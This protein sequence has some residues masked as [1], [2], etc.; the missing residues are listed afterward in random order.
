MSFDYS[1]IPTTQEECNSFEGV[2]AGEYRVTITD[3]SEAISSNGYEF[4]KMST[5]VIGGNHSGRKINLTFWTGGKYPESAYKQ[6]GA[7]MFAAKGK[8]CQLHE[9][10]NSTLLLTIKYKDGNDFPRFAG[11]KRDESPA[12]Q[13]QAAPQQPAPQAAPVDDTPF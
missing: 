7:I 8:G 9:L 4:V 10:V 6:L 3:C 13:Q 12:P 1:Q 2:P 11:C 5:E